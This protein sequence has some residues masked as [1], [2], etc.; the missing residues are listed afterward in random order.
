MVGKNTIMM[1][2]HVSQKKTTVMMNVCLSSF[3]A[4]FILIKCNSLQSPLADVN[5]TI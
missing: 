1:T 4:Y 3:K 5:S 2:L